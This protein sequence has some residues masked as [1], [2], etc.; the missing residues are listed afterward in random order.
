MG[1]DGQ[2]RPP[3][4]TGEEMERDALFHVID[5]QPAPEEQTTNIGNVPVAPRTSDEL[6]V[7]D[8]VASTWYMSKRR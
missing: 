4:L 8:A 1:T 6:L 5:D 7:R 2:E 3:L